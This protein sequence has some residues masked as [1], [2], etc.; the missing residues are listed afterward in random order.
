VNNLSKCYK[1][2]FANL[3]LLIKYGGKGMKKY[4]RLCVILLVGLLAGAT[5]INVACAAT[6][7]P[8]A[9]DQHSVYPWTVHA[10]EN[11]GWTS[12]SIWAQSYS[13]TPVGTPVTVSVS[14]QVKNWYYRIVWGIPVLTQGPDAY[15]YTFIEHSDGS[16]AHI[17]G[18]FGSSSL[19]KYELVTTHSFTYN[20][21]RWT[22]SFDLW[23]SF[24]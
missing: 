8:T 1:K 7:N 17:S 12:T 5:L 4:T 13:G 21:E 6:T 9:E 15:P 18:S 10:S 16:E 2:L 24:T 23:A 19:E 14:A 11:M 22:K 3:F 20:G